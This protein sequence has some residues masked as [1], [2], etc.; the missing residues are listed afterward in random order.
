MT[1]TIIVLMLIFF[2]TIFL[3]GTIRHYTLAKNI[4]DIPNNR[5]S[6]SI[7]TA[8]GGGVTIVLIFIILSSVLAA[9]QQISLSLF[10]ALSGGIIVAV[11]GWLDDVI[12]LLP[13]WRAVA[14]LLAAGWAV[15][16]LRGFPHW[17]IGGLGYVLAIIG[18]IWCVNLYNF[19]DGI[20]GLAGIEG[21]FICLSAAW[22][23]KWGGA[24]SMSFLCIVLAAAI[25]GFLVWNWPPAKIFM[26]D[27]GSGYLGFIFAVLA[28]ASE[29]MHVLPLT[30]WGIISGVFLCDATFTV[31]SRIY[32]GKR[33]YE[34]HREH[35]Y[36]RLVQKGISHKTVTTSVLFVNI[37]ILFPLSYAAFYYSR[38]GIWILI[39]VIIGLFILWNA[40]NANSLNVK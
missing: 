24:P 17:N 21:L 25:G 37:F 23:L 16:W 28:I 33:W 4:I 7:P 39:L 30:C 26:G 31:L 2:I 34:A 6:H 5:S 12:S 3:T 10:Y 38:G 8:R 15:Y 29:N 32:Q 22:M 40:I 19:M 35:A 13:R 18:I 14:Q 1:Q 27:V 11:V 9:R 36:Q 20:D